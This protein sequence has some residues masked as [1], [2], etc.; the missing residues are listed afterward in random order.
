M[1]PGCTENVKN[2]LRNHINTT[3]YC[4]AV[5][6]LIT[7]KSIPF[8]V[9]ERPEWMAMCLTLNRQAHPAFYKSH[10][11][12]PYELDST[13]NISNSWLSTYYTRQRAVSTS[14]RI[15]GMQESHIKKSFKQLT[16]SLLIKK[17]ACEKR[18]WHCQNCQVAIAMHKWLLFSN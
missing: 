17:V 13:L 16:L 10:T 18:Y 2:V 5:A 15:S 12:T 3:S 4:S 1:S 6:R 9:V 14:T 7:A 8:N 11:T